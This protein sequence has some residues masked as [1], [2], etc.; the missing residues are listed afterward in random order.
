VSDAPLAVPPPGRR[1]ALVVDFG[2][3]LTTPLL[4]GFAAFQDHSGVP[5]QALGRAIAAVAARDG[6]NPLHELELGHMTEADFLGR[7]A[8]AVSDDLGRPVELHDFTE[9]YFSALRANAPMVELVRRAHGAGWATALLTNNV[10][11]W[12]ARWR[13]MLPVDELFD[14]VVDSAQVGVRKPDPR[15]FRLA[16]TGLGDPPPEQVVFLDD[17]HG[18]IAAAERLGMR[19]ILV[20]EDHRPALEKLRVLL[21]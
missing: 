13:A 9:R 2:G 16:L 14:V 8:D 17:F 7:V 1:R 5:P 10:R 11:E 21:A 6:A 12:E 3:V 18:N 20:D 19:G 4:D 15:I